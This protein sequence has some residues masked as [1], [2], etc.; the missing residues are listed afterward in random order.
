M[1][2]GIDLVV[3]AAG[4][5][6]G[7]GAAVD[8]LDAANQL[9]TAGMPRFS[10]RCVGSGESVRLRGG[11]S[12]AATPLT[13]VEPH[14]WILLPG[15]GGG[16]AGVLTDRLTGSDIAPTAAWLRDA[17]AGGSTLVGSCTG[18]FLLGAAG[19]LD[20]R[21]CTTTW[22]LAGLLAR[23]HP[24]ARVD[25]D[26][27][28]VQDG[29]TWTGGALFSQVDLALA[30]VE[31]HH[32]GAQART[33]ANR[34]AFERRRSQ[35]D[36]MSASAYAEGAGEV[37]A[38]EAYA[39]AHL[40]EPIA[41]DDLAAHAGVSARTLARR[42]QAATGLAPMRL[43][44]RIRLQVALDRLRTTGDSTAR[45]AQSVGLADTASLY[46]LVKNATGRTPSQFR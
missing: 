37:A 1:D 27:M 44:Q 34:I 28:V 17:Y 39:L 10:L 9:A 14:E 29:P 22:W 13:G 7:I 4:S 42:T 45:I 40:T 32:G 36:F 26:Q 19:A 38:V 43:V 18:S 5:P 30:V 41:L 15:F 3:M 8:V 20:G 46:R 35:A 11:L 16:D 23:R 33:V 6:S 31:R 25:A 12:V 2:I 21:R 24:Q